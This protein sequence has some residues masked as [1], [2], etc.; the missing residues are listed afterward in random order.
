ML[1]IYKEINRVVNSR[2][3]LYSQLRKFPSSQ[4]SCNNLNNE[5]SHIIL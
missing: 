5:F 1:T 2:N 3:V 4:M